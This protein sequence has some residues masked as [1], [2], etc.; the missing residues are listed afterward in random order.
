MKSKLLSV[1]KVIFIILLNLLA[2]TLF[3]AAAQLGTADAG[4]ATE[5]LSKLGSR[6][7]LEM[8]THGA[9]QLARQGSL[10]GK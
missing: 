2:V 1:L 4:E 8:V 10:S 7:P 6:G 9:S 5:V 3:W